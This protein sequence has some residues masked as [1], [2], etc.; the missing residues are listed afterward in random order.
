MEKRIPENLMILELLD[1][2]LFY[3]SPV[4]R[5]FYTKKAWNCN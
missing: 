4:P 1:I 5:D 2:V 3:V